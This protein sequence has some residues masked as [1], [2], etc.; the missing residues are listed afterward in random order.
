MFY[1]SFLYLLTICFIIFPLTFSYF[2][3]ISFTIF[4]TTFLSAFF[5]LLR[6]GFVIF[7]ISF[8]NPFSIILI[9]FPVPLCLACFTDGVSSIWSCFIYSK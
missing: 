8:I 5:H 1:K 6:V 7:P 9:V 4:L 3:F 2:S